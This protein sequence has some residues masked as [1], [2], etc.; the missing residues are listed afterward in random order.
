M[1]TSAVSFDLSCFGNFQRLFKLKKS[2][3][4]EMFKSLVII[5]AELT[6]RVR[7]ATAT[8]PALRLFCNYKYII[9]SVVGTG[10]QRSTAN[11]PFA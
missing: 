7:F 8:L 10:K 6:G 5:I 9:F 2:F 4:F 1:A 3:V 11:L